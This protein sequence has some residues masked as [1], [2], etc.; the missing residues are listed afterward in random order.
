MTPNAVVELTTDQIIA[1]QN[2]DAGGSASICLISSKKIVRKTC[3]RLRSTAL[4][5]K[6][7]HPHPPPVPG[8]SPPQ[9]SKDSAIFLTL[10]QLAYDFFNSWPFPKRS[11][12]KTKSTMQRC[13][14]GC[15]LF[16]MAKNISPTALPTTPTISTVLS[17]ESSVPSNFNSAS[18]I[19]G[20]DDPL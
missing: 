1:L 8:R 17:P 7:S 3:W 13:S 14:L 4:Q 11:A 19:P 10:K 2:L 15:S 9:D 6:T 12:L 20:I 5:Y 16:A 18:P